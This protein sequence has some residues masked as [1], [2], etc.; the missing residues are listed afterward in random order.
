MAKLKKTAA[1][2]TAPATAAT[3]AP[4][5]RPIRNASAIVE[6]EELGRRLRKLRLER[7]LTLKQVERSAGLSATHLSEIERGRTSP[8]IGALVRI[9]RALDKDTSFFIERDERSDV[10]HLQRD[11]AARFQAAPG[12]EARV[13]TPGIPGSRLFAYGLT[14]TP[15]SG[16]SGELSVSPE[17]VDGEALYLVRSGSVRSSFGET[18]STLEV[19]DGV[20][21]CT[22]IPHRLRPAGTTPVELIAILTRPLENGN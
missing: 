12:V 14:L 3:R 18:E 1:R 16:R 9:A 22:S 7:R 11:Q 20:Q 4:E 2:K 5:L 19:G 8:T 21:A 15:G 10:V 17:E 13:L 6:T